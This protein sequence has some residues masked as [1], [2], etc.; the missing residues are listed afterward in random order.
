M[1][2]HCSRSISVERGIC[3]CSLERK[4]KRDGG[5]EE[6]GFTYIKNNCGG[7]TL[8]VCAVRTHALS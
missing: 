1:N 3:P 7:L 4:M 8:P 5:N 2:C 6:G